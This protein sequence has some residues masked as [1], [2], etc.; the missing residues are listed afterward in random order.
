MPPEGTD[1]ID[2]SAYYKKRYRDA[3]ANVDKIISDMVNTISTL[4][5]E[6]ANLRSQILKHA[7][8]K[9]IDDGVEEYD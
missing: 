6:N 2:I 1:M 5:H 3:E 9:D 7:N 8:A 4:Q